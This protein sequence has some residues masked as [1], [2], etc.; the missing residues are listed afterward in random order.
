MLLFYHVG[1]S[2]AAPKK[3]EK[4]PDVRNL[5][6]SLSERLGTQVEIKLGKNGK[7]KLVIDFHSKDV[8]QG[9]LEKIQ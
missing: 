9:I 5:E 4:D 6:N 8:L 7:G 2:S 1:L 3:K